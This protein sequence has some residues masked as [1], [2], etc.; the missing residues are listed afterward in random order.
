MKQQFFA[1]ALSLTSFAS[2]AAPESYSIDPNHTYPSFETSHIGISFWRGK[3][4][5]TEGKVILDR[6]AKTGSVEV[7]I[8]AKSIDFGH[9]KMN[10]HA[11]G[12][13]FFNVEKYPSISYKGKLIYTGDAPSAVEGVLTMHGVS[14]PVNLVIGSFKCIE[15]PMFKKEV[16][17]ADASAQ[18]DRVD[19]GMDYGAK[20]GPTAAKLSIQ[21]EA[22]KD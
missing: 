18:I 19:F 6:A 10:E 5:A 20:F 8:S 16:C 9:E 15:H 3:F 14:K 13:D 11:R 1:A 7:T 2:F 4:D 21:V 17:G 12:A 22:L